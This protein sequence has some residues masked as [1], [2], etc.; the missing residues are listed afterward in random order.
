[1]VA[2]ILQPV[3]L[4]HDRLRFVAAHPLDVVRAALEC[5]V[6]RLAGTY[7]TLF[8]T[9]R[10]GRTNP[11]QQRPR[12]LLQQHRPPKQAAEDAQATRVV[13]DHPLGSRRGERRQAMQRDRCIAIQKSLERREIAAREI[14]RFADF[15][16]QT[17]RAAEIDEV[18]QPQHFAAEQPRVVGARQRLGRGVR[19]YANRPAPRLQRARKQ[20][21]HLDRIGHRQIAQ[22]QQPAR[23]RGRKRRRRPVEAR[24]A[25]YV[26]QILRVDSRRI[27]DSSEKAAGRMAQ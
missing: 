26:L 12:G 21:F 11:I 27:A 22:Q 15:P 1:M 9:Q 25:F 7:E 2:G 20:H 17:F 18:L 8:D 24:L 4:E 6:I 3:A 5:G 10:Q 19:H 23:R 16:A 13:A 14:E